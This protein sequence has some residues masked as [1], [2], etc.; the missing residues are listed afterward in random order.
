MLTLQRVVKNLNVYGPIRVAS[1]RYFSDTT[2]EVTDEE[3]MK[4]IVEHI[5]AD[6]EKTGWFFF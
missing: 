2:K 4:K 6:S 5:K 1:N 3:T